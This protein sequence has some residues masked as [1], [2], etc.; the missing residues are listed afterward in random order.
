[1]FPPLHSLQPTSHH[2]TFFTSQQFTSFPVFLSQKDE[3][4]VGGSVQSSKYTVSPVTINAAPLFPSLQFSKGLGM[5]IFGVAKFA[6]NL[7]SVTA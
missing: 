5:V 4:A 1:L 2:A 7:Y 6:Q 3:G